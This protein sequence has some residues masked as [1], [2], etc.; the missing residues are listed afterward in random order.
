M[1]IN[2]DPLSESSPLKLK[3]THSI[4]KGKS[5]LDKLNGT[6]PINLKYQDFSGEKSP[7]E[8]RLYKRSSDKALVTF[9]N[10]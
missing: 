2:Q 6:S 8:L 7:I 3:Q 1:A 9:K 10:E 5:N 4:L